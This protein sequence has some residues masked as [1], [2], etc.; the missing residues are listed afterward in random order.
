[1]MNSISREGIL[2]IIKPHQDNIKGID[3]IYSENSRN[4]GY[5]PP[6]YDCESGYHKSD[7]HRTRFPEE[8]MRFYIIEPTNEHRRDK[9]SETKEYKH[10]IRLRWG[11]RVDQIEF[12]SENRHDEKSDKGETRSKSWNSIWPI[13]GI[14][15]DHIP[16]NGEDKGNEVY[17][18]RSKDDIILVEIEN[19]PEYI[20][21]ISDFDT[22]DTNN[23]PNSNLHHE[24]YLCTHKEW[25]ISSHLSK[26]FGR[27]FHITFALAIKFMNSIEII[28][29]AYQSDYRT[30]YQDDEKSVLIYITEEWI[31]EK[32][33][34]EE[35]EIEDTP[36]TKRYWF[37]LMPIGGWIIEEPETR[38]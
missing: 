3:Q 13:D 16:D 27:F 25:S 1:M 12:D 29:K 14:E 11:R 37:P 26:L 15:Y 8:N 20:G 6:S 32:R 38:E 2:L 4:G 22:R 7:E 10:G 21:N 19:S 23:G 18:E 24:S 17:L 5:F 9:N 28:Y 30:Q 34:E 31:K 36:D 33:E 35:I